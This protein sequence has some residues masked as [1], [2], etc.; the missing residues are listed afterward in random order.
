MGTD[1]TGF[2]PDHF[3]YFLLHD[4]EDARRWIREQVEYFAR[5][6]LASLQKSAPFYRTYDIGNLKLADSYCWV[7]F[8]PRGDGP[9]YRAVTHQT[10]SLNADGLRVF[11]NTE[12]KSATDRLKSV[13]KRTQAA[14]R[15]ELQRLHAFEPF[16]LVLEERVQRQRQ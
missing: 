9:K 1:F 11:V 10:M 15:A 2:R 6:V 13:L 12:L 3:H 7:A 8:G 14:L 16:E 5:D 4:D